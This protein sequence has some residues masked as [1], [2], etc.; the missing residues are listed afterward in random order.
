M[1]LLLLHHHLE[2][3][4][5][6]THPLLFSALRVLL[7]VLLEH[8]HLQDLVSEPPLL[9]QTLAN[10][11]AHRACPRGVVRPAQLHQVLLPH[12]DLRRLRWRTMLA[13]RN[14]QQADSTCRLLSRANA[15]RQAHHRR[16]LVQ[17]V[18]LHHLQGILPTKLRTLQL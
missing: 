12:L 16:L 8:H 5:Q 4:Q 9:L 2:N 17:V 3:P 15:F 11:Q 7:P 1:V 6:A 10:L 13:R 18:H 14:L